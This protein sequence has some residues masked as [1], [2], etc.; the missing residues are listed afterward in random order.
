M[1]LSESYKKRLKFLA[2]IGLMNENFYQNLQPKEAIQKA[3]VDHSSAVK[4]NN[5]GQADKI[6]GNLKAHLESLGYN[7]KQDPYAMEI[8]GDFL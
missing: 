8:L 4:Q 1:N 5:S 2:G 3:T 7:W 6:A